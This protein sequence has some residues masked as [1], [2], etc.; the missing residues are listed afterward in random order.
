MAST[1][2]SRTT[3]PL[4]ASIPTTRDEY[5]LVVPTNTQIEVQRPTKGNSSSINMLRQKMPWLAI[6]G[7]DLYFAPDRSSVSFICFSVFFIA[8]IDSTKLRWEFSFW[9]FVSNGFKI[10]QVF[11]RWLSRKWALSSQKKENYFYSSISISFSR[12]VFLFFLFLFFFFFCFLLQVPRRVREIS[13]LTRLIG[14]WVRG[15]AYGFDILT[16]GEAPFEFSTLFLEN[17]YT[18]MLLVRNP[19]PLQ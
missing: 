17:C 8:K 12:D 3:K 13:P 1:A 2:Q 14:L 19:P 6:Q 18:N 9:G 7:S 11:R 16:P 5:L 10:G 15:D 4:R